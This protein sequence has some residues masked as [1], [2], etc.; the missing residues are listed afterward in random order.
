MEDIYF[1]DPRE[2]FENALARETFTL[3]DADE[4]MYMYS[5]EGRDYFKHIDTRTYTQVA[6][7]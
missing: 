1:I 6:A 4:Y 2:A 7:R 3:Q 5:R